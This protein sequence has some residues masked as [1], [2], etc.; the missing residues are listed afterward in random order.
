MNHQMQNIMHSF[1]EEEN[2]TAYASLKKEL[3]EEFTTIFEKCTMKGEAHNQL[4]NY[5]K[6]MIAFFEGLES[7]DLKFC[8]A[9]F[10]KMETHENYTKY[11][12]ETPYVSVR[13]RCV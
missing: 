9:N 5:L 7:S 2:V 10:E 1:S 4:H 6:P 12:N 8:K 3:E 13:N 11:E